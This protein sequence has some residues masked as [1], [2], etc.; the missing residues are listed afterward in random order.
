MSL[1]EVSVVIPTYNGSRFI[2][3]ALRSVFAQTQLPREIIVVDDCSTD[4]ASWAV[5]RARTQTPDSRASADCD[6]ATTAAPIARRLS[7]V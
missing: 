3:D 7:T 4:D 6:V 5:E 2:A 1:P